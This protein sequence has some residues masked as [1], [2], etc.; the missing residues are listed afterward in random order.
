LLSQDLSKFINVRSQFGK[1]CPRFARWLFLFFTHSQASL[2]RFKNKNAGQLAGIHLFAERE[3]LFLMI[4][5]ACG[6]RRQTNECPRFARWLFLFFTHSQASLLR[7][8][9]K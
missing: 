4:P 1:E 9:N 7:F 6:G 2:L 3:G 8:K 5:F